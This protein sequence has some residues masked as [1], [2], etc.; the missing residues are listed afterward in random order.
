MLLEQ[1]AVG[2]F[3]QGVIVGQAGD[4]GLGALAV[5]DVFRHAQQI[6]GLA[7]GVGDGDLLGA[8]HGQGAILS[9][10]QVLLDDPHLAGLDDL[11]VA[12]DIQGGVLGRLEV[13]VGLADHLLA[14]EAQGFLTRPVEQNI[15][16]IVGPLDEDHRGHGLDDGG[17]E[18][19]RP[20]GVGLGGGQFGDAPAIGLVGGLQQ[21]QHGA[22]TQIAAAI[23]DDEAA[24][25]VRGPVRQAVGREVGQGG[26]G[27]DHQRLDI[28]QRRNRTVGVEGATVFGGHPQEEGVALDETNRTVLIVEHRN[29]Q[30]IGLLAEPLIECLAQVVATRRSQGRNGISQSKH[31]YASTTGGNDHFPANGVLIPV[32]GNAHFA[33]TSP[34]RHSVCKGVYLHC[35]GLLKHAPIPLPGESRG[36]DRTASFAGLG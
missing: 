3:G 15:A 17:H 31:G 35:Q 5:S 25:Q 10:D 8:K 22:D 32:L 13:G 24:Q 20:F 9:R 29:D 12:L 26:V 23:G 28:H 21:G 18:D 16:V 4:L 33:K 27:V 1:H 34:G 2:Q 19:L 7:V 14:R 11:A 36:P 30:G 6:L